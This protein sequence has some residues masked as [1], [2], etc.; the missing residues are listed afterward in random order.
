MNQL[1]SIISAIFARFAEEWH[2]YALKWTMAHLQEIDSTGAANLDLNETPELPQQFLHQITDEWP[3]E[4]AVLEAINSELQQLI[5]GGMP[6]TAIHAEL[7]QIAQSLREIDF[8]I[9]QKLQD[10]YTQAQDIT[11]LERL[12]GTNYKDVL[13]FDRYLREYLYQ[14]INEMLQW[15]MAKIIDKTMY[16]D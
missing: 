13:R 10:A 1:Q 16:N 3:I 4:P 15:H 11:I 5:S 6:I 14:N 2:D 12:T 8:P 7:A 9:P